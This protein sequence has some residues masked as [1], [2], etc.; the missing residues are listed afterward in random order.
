MG[1]AGDRIFGHPETG[2]EEP[3]DEI[4]ALPRRR[5]DDAT[6]GEPGERREIGRD[7]SHLGF[8][9]EQRE[10][11]HVGEH[12]RRRR[13]QP[14]REI[15]RRGDGVRGERR[16][17]HGQSAVAAGHFEAPAP[18]LERDG[19]GLGAQMMKHDMGAREGRVAAQID[20]G[21]RCKPAQIIGPV[22]RNEKRRLGQVVLASDR[23][24]RRVG[25][26]G[27]ERADS[28]RVAAEHDIGERIDLEHPKLHATV[29]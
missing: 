29:Y 4:L 19:A 14:R 10:I 20:L 23:L 7:R 25:E 2:A 12:G 13:A 8:M 26:P 5:H 21:H 16:K 9:L 17:I 27:V 24:E 15:T 18:G 1:R 22:R 28:G 6:P 11:V 3:R